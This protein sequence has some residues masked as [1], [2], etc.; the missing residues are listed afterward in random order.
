MDRDLLD[1]EVRPYVIRLRDCRL[2]VARRRQVAPSALNA[3]SVQLRWT[4]LATG[5][6]A[7]VRAIAPPDTDED[8]MKCLSRRMWAWHFPSPP[9]GPVDVSYQL[10]FR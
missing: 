1:H 6:T 9:G 7:E 10:P 2:E 8:V 3:G 5:R 4:I